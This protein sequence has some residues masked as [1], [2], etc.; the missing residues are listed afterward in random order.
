[1]AFEG[2]MSSGFGMM[3]QAMLA[4]VGDEI[5]LTQGRQRMSLVYSVNT[6]A[7]KIAGA[8]SIGLAFPLLQLLGFNGR[9]GAVNTAQAIRNLDLAFLAGPIVFV[10]LGGACVIGWRLDS[11]RHDEIRTKLAVRDAE[12]DAAAPPGPEP[13]ES[14]LTRRGAEA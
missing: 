12:L 5:R 9:E 14:S 11:K 6:L 8:A 4:D 3:I 10:M 2:M 13:M 1:M 7:T